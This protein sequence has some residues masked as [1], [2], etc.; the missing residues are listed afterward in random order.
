GPSPCRWAVRSG[1]DDHRDDHRTAAQ[2]APDPAAH[3]AADDL[4]QLVGVGDP[5]RGGVGDR[6]LDPGP[7]LVEDLLLLGEAARLDLRACGDLAGGRV[8]HDEHGDESLVAQD[9]A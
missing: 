3:A 7:D 2:L 5:P 4:L 6:V 8:A 9:P 1:V